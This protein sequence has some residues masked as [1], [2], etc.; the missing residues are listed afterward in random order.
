MVQV[1]GNYVATIYAQQALTYLR[2]R[3]G[4]AARVYRG[5][6]VNNT[7]ERFDSIKI[8]RPM[9][10]GAAENEPSTVVDLVPDNLTLLMNKWMGKR[11]AVTDKEYA[12]AAEG[13]VP[14]HL[15]T[16]VYSVADAIDQSLIALVPT[17]PHSFMEAGAT[18][19]VA[20][21]AGT[22]RKLFDNL[23]PVADEANM[24]FMIG[25]QERAD[26]TSL[27]A[28]SQWQGAGPTGEETQLS[29]QIDRRY[30]FGF[31]ATQNRGTVA[32][33]DIT[34]TD[35]A[36]AIN[37]GAGYA[38]GTTTIVVDGLVS[39]SDTYVAGTIL[40]ITSGDD[41][42]SEYALTAAAVNTTGTSTFL[43]NPGLRHAVLDNATFILGNG[44]ASASLQD[45]ATKNQN[46][47]FHR[48]WAALAMG[49]LP[50]YGGFDN[51]LGA[52]I[53]TAYDEEAKVSVRTKLFLDNTNSKLVCLV[54][55][56]WGV[57]EL[58]P[59]MACRYEIT[60]A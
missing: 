60:A 44:T 14:Q 31:F 23:A 1:L 43:I 47:A 28:F 9:L 41:T 24:H 29:G 8:R 18:V 33:N 21:I 51:K 26:L 57:L 56:L 39:A 59:E 32:Y 37:N 7:F 5:F 52:E 25:G 45:A 38:K 10:F 15:E 4:M 53:G 6:D 11:F 58:N 50:D 40:K 22:A 19:S 27:A 54:D 36:G 34:V 55:A 46:L 48:D 20:G 49:R 2:K 35:L 12:Q 17:V 42:G 13:L 30:G 3:L 16:A